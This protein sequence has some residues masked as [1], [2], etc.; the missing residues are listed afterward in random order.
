[1]ALR[2]DAERRERIADW[3]RR[4]P[5][6]T[7]PVNI[8]PPGLNARRRATRQERR[9]VLDIVDHHQQQIAQLALDEARLL[10]PALRQAEAELAQQLKRWTEET[11]DGELRWT[12]QSYR[13]AR[14]F[15]GR[16]IQA[17][18]LALLELV[19]K[20]TARAQ[21]MA[22]RHLTEEVARF[23]AIF[24]VPRTI[25]LDVARQVATGRS[26]IIPRVRTSAARYG[27]NIGADI[28]Q[29]LLVDI[30]KGASVY[31]T[32]ERLVQSAGPRGFVSLKGVAGEEG[33]VVEYIPE[34]LFVRFRSWAERIVRTETASAYGAQRQMG[35]R[36]AHGQLPRL[37]RRWFAD[38]SACPLICL[39]LNGVV[40][41]VEGTWST[42]NGSIDHEP[43]HP[44]CM[45]TTQPWS[46]DWPALLGDIDP[47]F[48]ARA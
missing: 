22:L 20:S 43:A 34:G 23:S 42:P 11:P 35:L 9:A 48:R 46:S 12:A 24:G 15:A 40:T 26:Y 2:P 17:L 31:E 16:T 7:P 6:R 27:K 18:E 32:T 5:G 19:D 41:G 25:S 13:A 8:E 39:P 10:L 44:N 38:P 3:K 36:E 33:A 37:R 47:A 28:Q 1:M 4:H 30:L 14:L 45:C 29:R 21:D